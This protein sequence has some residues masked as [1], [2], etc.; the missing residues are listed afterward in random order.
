MKAAVFQGAGEPLRIEEVPDPVPGPRDLVLD[1]QA[2]GICGS[3]L[4]VS[5]L[6]GALPGGAVMG[7]EFAGTVAEVGKE[8]G[9]AFAVGDLVTALPVIGCAACAACLSGD[10]MH[11]TALRGTGLGDL[12]GAFAEYVRVGA[13]ESLHLPDGVDAKLGALVEPLAVALHAV[14]TARLRSG[15]KVLVVGAGPIGLAITLWCRFFGARDVVVSELAEGRRRLASHL[16]ATA[17]IDAAG[18]VGGAFADTTGGPPDVI[19]ECVGVPGMLNQCVALAPPRGRI[20]VAGVCIES[21]TFSPVLAIMKE[22][23]LQFVLAYGKPDFAFTLDMLAAGRLDAS[24]LVTDFVGLEGLPEAFEA[25][26]QPGGQCK[27]LL[28]F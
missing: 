21:D 2:C 11:C 19:F 10:V 17:A 5:A 3:D 16:G 23:R 7:H 22:L 14:E 28:E 13:N 26:R 27:V 8:V 9:D 12:P 15:E 25:L 4:H 1:V 20:V 18:D 24:P 6:P